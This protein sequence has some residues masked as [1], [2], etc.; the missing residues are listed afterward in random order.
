MDELQDKRIFLTGASGFIG[1]NLC[2]KLLRHGACVHALV[3]PSSNL[4]RLQDLQSQLAIHYADITNDRELSRIVRLVEP[5]L[6][7]H[8]AFPSG[9]PKDRENRQKMIEIGLSGTTNLLEAVLS[10]DVERVLAFGSSMG[11]EVQDEPLTESTPIHPSSLRGAVKAA[12]T[13]LC[14]HYAERHGQ[15]ILVLRPFAVYGPWE[16]STRFIPTAILALL[17]GQTLQLTPPGYRHDFLFIKDLMEV[18]ILACKADLG[19]FEIINV[20][21]SQEWTNEEVVDILQK[22]SGRNLDYKVGTFQPRP[23]DAAH[24]VADI[25]KAKRLLGWKPKYSLQ[26]GLEKTLAW[27]RQNLH[28]YNTPSM[29]NRMDAACFGE[30]THEY[31]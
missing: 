4:W 28:L 1:A 11:Y 17:R 19:D 23:W 24:W 25:H 10:I 30:A 14:Q 6:V 13:I 7:I 22:L 26:H 5:Q 9:H 12:G 20:G 16:S 2:R 8:A 18:S 27:F 3:R 21:T 29:D 15:R 31:D